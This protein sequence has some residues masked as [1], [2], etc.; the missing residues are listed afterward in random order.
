MSW[1]RLHMHVD[2]FFFL[3]GPRITPQLNFGGAPEVA[4]RPVFVPVY[5]H[6]WV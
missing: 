1:D 6:V 2:A 3:M 4:G 5:S